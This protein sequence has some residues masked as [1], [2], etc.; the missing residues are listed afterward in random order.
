MGYLPWGVKC[1]HVYKKK[2][3][4]VTL[5]EILWSLGWI[6]GFPKFAKLNNTH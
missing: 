2:T 3:P 1:L 5:Q 6:V 4:K